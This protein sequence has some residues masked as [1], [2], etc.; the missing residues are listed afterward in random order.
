ME[1]EKRRT[2]FLNAGEEFYAPVCGEVNLVGEVTFSGLQD[3]ELI[4]S[5][6]PWVLSQ[7]GD[8]GVGSEIRSWLEIGG[9]L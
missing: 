2:D 3:V 8:E 9:A 1:S 4:L 5:A 7:V 6:L